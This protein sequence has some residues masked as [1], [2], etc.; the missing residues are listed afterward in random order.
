MAD[1]TMQNLL[2]GLGLR[3]ESGKESVME[4]EL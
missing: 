3:E 1:M 4:A 2:G